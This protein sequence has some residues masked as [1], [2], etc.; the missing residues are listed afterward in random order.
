MVGKEREMT[1]K[2]MKKLTMAG[3]KD[4]NLDEVE[5]ILNTIEDGSA[6]FILFILI[7]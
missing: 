5:G 1:Q 3:K 2:K 4:K 6:I 7:H